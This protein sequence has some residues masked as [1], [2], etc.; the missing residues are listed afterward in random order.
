MR[1]EE[2]IENLISHKISK[3]VAIDMLRTIAN[4]KIT[5]SDLK[6]KV[7]GIAST[8]QSDT[9]ILNLELPYQYKQMQGKF[10]LNDRV[11]VELV[12]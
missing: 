2:I 4:K 5:D 10:K 9:G 7:T 12:Y 8:S 6:F 1:I 3:D 11:L